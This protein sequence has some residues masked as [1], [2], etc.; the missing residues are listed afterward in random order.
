MQRSPRLIFLDTGF[1]YALIDADDANH[2]RV[3]EVDCVSF[4]VMEKL[5]IE[6]AWTVDGDFQHRFTA[7]PGPPP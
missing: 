4:V 1:L 5:G 7:L 3:K 6:V 2:L